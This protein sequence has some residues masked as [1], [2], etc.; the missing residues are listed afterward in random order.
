MNE[1]S[2]GVNAT[3]GGK[4]AEIKTTLNCRNEVSAFKNRPLLSLIRRAARC[5]GFWVKEQ[6]DE[7]FDS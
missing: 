2:Y 6:R 1:P 5:G 7:F 3:D 4:A